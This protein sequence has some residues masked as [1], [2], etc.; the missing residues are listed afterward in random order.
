MP[1]PRIAAPRAGRRALLGGL[2]RIR[3]A[4]GRGV[5]VDVGRRAPLGVL[6]RILLLVAAL[7]ALLPIPALAAASH[8]P[9]LRAARRAPAGA[10]Y[11]SIRAGTQ[12]GGVTNAVSRSRAKPNSPLFFDL[13]AH[14]GARWAREEFRWDLIEPQRGRWDWAAHDQTV[15]G[16]RREGLEIIG[17]LAYSA[18]WAV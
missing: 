6:P 18:G 11:T 5:D 7:C 12:P 13:V 3:R 2:P 4:V 14:S 15:A 8:L 16:Y 10:S 17:L 9:A 1:S